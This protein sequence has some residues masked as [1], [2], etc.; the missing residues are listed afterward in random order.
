MSWRSVISDRL[1]GLPITNKYLIYNNIY[2]YALYTPVGW[3]RLFVPTRELGGRP[4]DAGGQRGDRITAQNV[5][6]IH[7]DR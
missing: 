3:A 2:P 5:T 4:Q 1:L 7:A 6:T